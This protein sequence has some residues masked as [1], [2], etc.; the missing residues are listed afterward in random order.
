MNGSGPPAAATGGG[1]P[2]IPKT[3]VG[4]SDVQ[5]SRRSGTKDQNRRFFAFYHK[6]ILTET[7]KTPFCYIVDWYLIITCGYCYNAGI[8]HASKVVGF[9][10][11]FF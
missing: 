5:K 8:K 7:F 6:L 3:R 1:A 2:G 9:F 11:F 4:D 10:L